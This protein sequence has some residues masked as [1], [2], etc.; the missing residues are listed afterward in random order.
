MKKSTKGAVKEAVKE[1]VKKAEFLK[2]VLTTKGNGVVFTTPSGE[3]YWIGLEPRVKYNP[4]TGTQYV[5]KEYPVMK[6]E[7]QPEKEEIATII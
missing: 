7:K 2:A 4:Y 6:L 5:S 3:T 1:E